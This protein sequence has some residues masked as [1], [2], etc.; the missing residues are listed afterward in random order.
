MILNAQQVKE[1]LKIGDTRLRRLVESGKL[2][3]VNV[4]KPGAKKFFMRFNSADVNAAAKELKLNGHAPRVVEKPTPTEPT[5]ILSRLSA[6]E[7]KL[8]TL[9]RM[10]S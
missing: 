2:T 4:R 10:W 3:P 1:K 8:D 9:I 5:G 6:I 7:S